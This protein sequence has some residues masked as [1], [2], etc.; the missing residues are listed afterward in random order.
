MQP[1]P[2]RRAFTLVELLV[3]VA[4]IG[5][6]VALLLPA[7]QAARE[8]ARRGRCTNQLRNVALACLNFESAR[9]VLPPASVNAPVEFDNSIGWQVLILP[10]LEEGALTAS[11]SSADAEDAETLDLANRT[12]VPV[13]LCPTDPDIESERGRKFDIQVMSYAGVLGS[14]FSSVGLDESGADCGPRDRCVGGETG[15]TGEF[16][17]V[18]VDGLMGVD[19]AV[20]LRRVTDGLSKTLLV[21]ERWYQLRTWTF[22]SYFSVRDDG[23]PVGDRPPVGPQARTAVSAAK[24]LDRRSPLNAD[25]KSVGFYRRHLDEDRPPIGAGDEKTI[26]YNNLP[27]GSFHPGGAFFAH[28][29]ASVRFYT[30]DINEAVYL[31]LGSRDGGEV[32][33]D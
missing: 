12:T 9:G 13:Y 15:A 26:A 31:A 27:F 16:G 29:D 5:V 33:A 8:A 28:G 6:L 7:V 25:L 20:P 18:N 22:G 24:N 4:I 17:T 32:A 19:I 3:V 2:I 11:I 1:H 30:D 23:Q 14:Y 21:G 10:Y